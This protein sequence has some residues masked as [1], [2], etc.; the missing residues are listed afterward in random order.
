MSTEQSAAQTVPWHTTVA[1]EWKFIQTDL[2]TL[3]ASVLWGVVMTILLQ[4]GERIDTALFG[5]TFVLFAMFF[6]PCAVGWA[7]FG[8]P[9]A[10]IT[11]LISPIFA[12]ML[13]STPLAPYFFLSNTLLAV[14]GAV[15]FAFVK[16]KGEG[17][18]IWQTMFT[19]GIGMAALTLPYLLYIWPIAVGLPAD[20][21]LKF[22]LLFIIEGATGTGIFSFLVIKR[23]LQTRL[24]P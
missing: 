15:A 4:I 19:S 14:F 22:G 20:L 21:A 5:G 17:I 3:I 8:L 23:A 6:Q 10:L 13:A 11:L 12:V 18:T 16:R 24:W 9:G 2:K 1:Y 7:L